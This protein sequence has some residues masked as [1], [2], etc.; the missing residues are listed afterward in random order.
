MRVADSPKNC[1]SSPDEFASSSKKAISIVSHF[2]T[3]CERR[4]RVRC[5]AATPSPPARSSTV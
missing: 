4:L 3:L 5:S 1:V 2:E